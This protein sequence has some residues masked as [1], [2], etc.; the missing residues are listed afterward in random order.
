MID[1]LRQLK[2]TMPRLRAFRLATFCYLVAVPYAVADDHVISQKDR[3]FYQS[4]GGNTVEIT[5]MTV[6]TGDS[7]TFTN[8]DDVTHNIYS[9]SP[10]NEFEIPKQVPGTSS[11]VIMKTPG[12]VE[13]RC[14]IHPKMKLKIT[15]ENG[16][17]TA[18]HAK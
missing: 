1:L 18:S 9:K 13:V 7:L 15:V 2:C 14:Q 8:S 5:D 12:S 4:D 3:A 6:K 16:D 11:T 17:P 10:G